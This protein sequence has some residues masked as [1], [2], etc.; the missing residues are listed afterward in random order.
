VELIAGGEARRRIHARIHR[1]GHVAVQRT[2][3]SVGADGIDDECVALPAADR[4][5]E[6]RGKQLVVRRMAA[7]VG[8]DPPWLRDRLVMDD[9]EVWAL[10]DLDREQARRPSTPPATT[11]CTRRV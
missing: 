6:K 2:G 11:D 4:V 8:V 3:P 5:T 10:E 9:D 7:T 1:S